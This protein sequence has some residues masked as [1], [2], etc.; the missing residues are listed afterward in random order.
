MRAMTIAIL[1]T[2]M[3][4]APPD[5]VRWDVPNV[6]SDQ[7]EAYATLDPWAPRDRPV[8]WYVRSKPDFSGWRIMVSRCGPDGWSRPEDAP[9][10]GDGVEADPVFT[11]G[12]RSLWFISTRTTDGVKRDDLDI[13]RVS[14]DA[15]GKWGTPER[16]PAPINSTAKEW[17]PQLTRDG[18][19]YFGSGRPGGFGKTDIWRGR[20]D[21]AGKWTV[22]NAGPA[23]NSAG[24]EFEA[25][26]TPDGQRM[27]L[28]AGDVYYESRRGPRGWLPRV[29]LGPEVNATGTEVGATLSPSGRAWLF[30]RDAKD[31]RSGEF[32]R[33][34][35]AEPGWPASCPPK[36]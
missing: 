14:R 24:N 9:I 18:W 20:Q 13:W 5:A 4:A 10:A 21:R 12:G 25:L 16:L 11:D 33:I 26:I 3:A 36:G 27:L 19:L 22:E 17:F 31:G 8:L 29:K 30:G 32:Y 23:I 15:S 7:F 28:Q 2:L 1:L 6:S 35:P 34:G